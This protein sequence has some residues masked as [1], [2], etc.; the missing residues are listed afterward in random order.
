MQYVHNK[1]NIKICFFKLRA[2]T[3]S[4]KTIYYLEA[5]RFYG[6]PIVGNFLK[7]EFI[8][9]VGKC[10]LQMTEDNISKRP[11]DSGVN[12]PSK[13]AV[14]AAAATA[15]ILLRKVGKKAFVRKLYVP[16]WK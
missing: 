8:K 16:F 2:Q 6:W 14:A 3:A 1:F 13:I 4:S 15:A 12:G 11:A 9:S 7:W 5:E 10:R